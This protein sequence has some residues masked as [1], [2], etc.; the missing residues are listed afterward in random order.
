M[1]TSATMDDKAEHLGNGSRRT[2]TFAK[3]GADRL[4]RRS[5]PNFADLI[6][7]VEDL[8]Q[9]VGHIADSEV[10]QVR[11]R[12]QEKIS[13]VKDT[14]AAEGMQIASA[15]RGAARA[16]DDYVHENPWRSTGVA[17]LVGLVLAFVVFRR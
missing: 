2:G 1:N 16:A 13:N 15:A 6:A 8:L 10:A 9:K 17:A 5:S 3:R 14:L 7:D 11:E 4:R 12:L